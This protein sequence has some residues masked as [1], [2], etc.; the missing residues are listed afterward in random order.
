MQ[1]TK[2][3]NMH[4]APFALYSW[5]PFYWSNWSYSR[6]G[7]TLLCWRGMVTITLHYPAWLVVGATLCDIL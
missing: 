7:P 2:H 6:A 4:P 1:M 3:S 5:F